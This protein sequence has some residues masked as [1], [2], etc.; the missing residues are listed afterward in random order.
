MLDQCNAVSLTVP[1]GP[2]CCP[3]GNL[4]RASDSVDSAKDGRRRRDSGSTESVIRAKIA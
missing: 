4:K 2:Q 3:A 1:P